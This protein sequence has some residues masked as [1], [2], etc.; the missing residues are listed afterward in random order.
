MRFLSIRCSESLLLHTY[1]K[2]GEIGNISIKLGSNTFKGG[3]GA[4]DG[5]VDSF[6]QIGAKTAGKMRA[7]HLIKLPHFHITLALSECGQL[8]RLAWRRWVG[9]DRISSQ[10]HFRFL[11]S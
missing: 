10:F 8:S 11:L 7:L 2:W 4:N 6:G 3:G 5:G 1:I 9:A